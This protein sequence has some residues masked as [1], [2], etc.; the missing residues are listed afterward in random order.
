VK[1]SW[2]RLDEMDSR[3]AGL[4]RPINNASGVISGTASGMRAE[5][6]C[7]GLAKGFGWKI[8]LGVVPDLAATSIGTTSAAQS[9]ICS[10]S[11]ICSS[12]FRSYAVFKISG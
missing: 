12:T 3:T 8:L 1:V 2:N 9:Y 11:L 7:V 6:S 10:G 5:Q 4:R